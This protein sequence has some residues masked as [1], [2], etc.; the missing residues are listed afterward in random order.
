MAKQGKDEKSPSS[1]GSKGTS[2]SGEEETKA[3]KPV[4]KSEPAPKKQPPKAVEEEEEQE[5]EEGDEDESE[6]ESDESD[7]SED[8]DESESSDESDESDDAPEKAAA[9]SKEDEAEDESSEE[10]ADESDDAEGDDKDEEVVLPSQ[11]GLQRYIFSAYFIVTV[12]L[13]YVMGRTIHDLLWA[14]FANRDFFVKFSPTLAAVPDDSKAILSKLNYSFALGGVIAILIVWRFYRRPKTKQWTDEVT[15]EL[16]K[17]RWPTRKE[18]QNH[19]IVVIA[20]SAAS[21]AYLFLL[22]RLWAFITGL[23]YGNGT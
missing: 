16:A 12:L 9:S 23:V 3:T 10:D 8:A 15:G 6:D 19:T 17:V 2:T 5:E 7:E 21:T 1:K 22:D 18:V 13:A 4:A 11:L 20:A 14:K